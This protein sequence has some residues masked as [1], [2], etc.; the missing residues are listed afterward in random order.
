MK[1]FNILGEKGLPGFSLIAVP[2]EI[3]ENNEA[4]EILVGVRAISLDKNPKSHVRYAQKFIDTFPTLG[5]ERSETQPTTKIKNE[6]GEE[7]EYWVYSVKSDKIPKFIAIINRDKEL[8]RIPPELLTFAKHIQDSP[9][10]IDIQY[11]DIELPNFT[12][13]KLKQLNRKPYI[14][15]KVHKK[16]VPYL[17]KNKYFN[18]TDLDC[19]REYQG[20]Y[21]HFHIEGRPSVL[22]ALKVIKG[23]C[24]FSNERGNE[25]LANVEKQ[26]S[27]YSH[28]KNPAPPLIS[29]SIND[30]E[31]LEK[32]STV[33]IND[34]RRVK[35]KKTGEILYLKLNPTHRKSSE[36][37]AFLS[38]CYAL[39]IGE[40]AAVAYS[41]HDDTG[42]KV[43][44]AYREVKQF[45]SMR[46]AMADFDDR[47]SE[48]NLIANGIAYILM[49]ALRFHETDLNSQNYGFND[50]GRLV[51]LD[52]G[53]SLWEETAKYLNYNRNQ[54][55]KDKE[56]D[57]LYPAPI[58]SFKFIL[59]DFLNINNLKHNFP[60]NW[61]KPNALNN[62]HNNPKF[63]RDVYK[64][65]IKNLLITKEI[66]SK[67]AAATISSPTGRE[68]MLKLITAE[69]EQYA[70]IL[71]LDAVQQLIIADPNIEKEIL[72]ELSLFNTK[73]AA[74]FSEIHVN[75]QQISKNFQTIK[76]QVKEKIS[77]KDELIKMIQSLVE[78]FTHMS[79]DEID[80]DK[81]TLVRSKLNNLSEKIEDYKIT[82]EY[83]KIL[84]ANNK[85]IKVSLEDRLMINKHKLFFSSFKP[86]EKFK[87]I[88]NNLYDI[89]DQ[90]PT[91]EETKK[92]NESDD[93]DDSLDG[94]SFKYSFNFCFSP[95][96][97]SPADPIPAANE[98]DENDNATS[99]SPSFTMKS[100]N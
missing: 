54:E 81:I 92:E 48:E 80:F 41:V 77:Q 87:G 97:T 12:Y 55:Y 94:S 98:E 70:K 14:N 93:S 74:G 61:E 49:A 86:F 16:Y 10:L 78:T 38:W 25:V 59:E 60:Y 40:N 57:K 43:A 72:N 17:K 51:K 31:I 52:H 23:K 82:P 64:F 18:L 29:K 58:K 44:V 56:R 4:T 22:H 13:E 75:I 50:Q 3:N 8:H 1:I 99:R 83:L 45:T 42:E 89:I 85:N 9:T 65:L 33:S 28:Q 100:F 34:V 84:C 62:A 95:I 7:I 26:L 36:V 30:F 63:R 69:F 15:F 68:K 11:E 91:T 24:K 35:D 79:T 32:V 39:L 73:I 5:L 19:N 96:Q 90:L 88:L 67:I 27:D 76:E 71:E 20:D 66:Y 47:I 21:L 53:L 6:N 46:N 37:E 2:E